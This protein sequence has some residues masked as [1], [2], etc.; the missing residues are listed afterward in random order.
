MRTLILLSVCLSITVSAFSQ[1][2]VAYYPFNGN[3]NDESGNN[4]NPTYTGAGVTLTTDR[5]GYNNKAYFFDGTPGPNYS[6]SGSYMRMPADNLPTGNR[7]VSLW[8]FTNDVNNMPGLLGYGGN[9]S[10]GTTYLMGINLSGA[11]QFH[12]Q[13]H[14]GNNTAAYAYVSAPIN[15]WYQWV[16][17]INGS[18]QKI[19]VNGILKSTDN[20]FSGSTA[21]TG[22]DFALGAITHTNGLSPYTDANVGFFHG[23]LDDVR[24][25]DNAMS[26][27][28]VFQLY[29]TESTGM[30]AYYPFNGNAN[31]ESGNGINPVYNGATLTTDRFGNTNSAYYFNGTNAV[32]SNYRQIIFRQQ[33][34]LYLLAQC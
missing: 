4:I 28:Q 10:C 3:N 7:T 34:V 26:D 23:K 15:N 31:D 2:L 22:V 21:T 18:T 29:K 20:T 25:Y 33:T 19:Y 16:L 8:F 14:C 1:N 12:V 9:G 17:T 27:A 13:G 5:F 6:I 24:I 32:I 30:T 11:G